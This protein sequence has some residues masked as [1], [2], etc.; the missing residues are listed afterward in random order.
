[1]ARRWPSADKTIRTEIPPGRASTTVQAVNTHIQTKHTRRA[2][3]HSV[4]RSINYKNI[5]RKQTFQLFNRTPI[6]SKALNPSNNINKDCTTL[7]LVNP[8]APTRR[9]TASH[10]GATN[11][12]GISNNNNNN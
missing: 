10:G 12:Q 4:N 11:K 2:G 5:L 3:S 8:S 7:L 6:S 1:M 9:I